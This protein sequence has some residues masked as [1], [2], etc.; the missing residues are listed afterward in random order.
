[1]VLRPALL[2]VAAALLVVTIASTWSYDTWTDQDAA[3][4][5][6]ALDS[7]FAGAA[8]GALGILAWRPRA[9][10]WALAFAGAIGVV[11]PA[12]L[13]VRSGW[14]ALTVVAVALGLVD[15]AGVMRQRA[16]ARSWSVPVVPDVD[17]ATRNAL[18]AFEWRALALAALGVAAVVFGTALWA[19]DDAAVRSFRADAVTGTALVTAVDDEDLTASATVDGRSFTLPSD[20][21]SYDVGDEVVV[22]Y[23]PTG[24]RIEDLAAVF[25]PTQ[26]LFFV[27]AGLLLALVAGGGEAG[28]RRAW[29]RLLAEGA[30]AAVVR[31][32][33]GR[34]DWV[35]LVAADATGA[36]PLARVLP[37]SLVD[38]PDGWR[39]DLG[40]DLPDDPAGHGSGG[41]S[42]RVD[43]DAPY[44][45]FP[46]SAADSPYGDSPYGGSPYGGSLDDE[47]EDEDDDLG[48]ADATDEE[49]LRAAADL[50]R[51]DEADLPVPPALPVGSEVVVVGLGATGDR[52]LLEAD[53]RWWWS[54]RPSRGHT[55]RTPARAAWTP[56]P[57]A[58]ADGSG[59]LWQ[60]LERTRDAWA[61]RT[62]RRTPLAV[63]FVLG[64]L[65]LVPLT[66]WL[67]AEL[68]ILQAAMFTLAAASV[69]F[70][71][72]HNGR[73]QLRATPD[74]VWQRGPFVDQFYRWD[75]IERF[76]TDGEAL[77]VRLG[78]DALLL[79]GGPTRPPLLSG[80]PEPEAAVRLLESARPAP[81]LRPAGNVGQRADGP[82][83]PGL[84]ALAGAVWAASVVVPAVGSLVSGG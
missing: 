51:E 24:Q 81:G 66:S 61:L 77:V 16:I 40:D 13:S 27:T 82:R 70:I 80:D 57:G 73:P 48:V 83:R 76:V 19:H 21:R 33:R 50:H 9:G 4:Y 34:G 26:S 8:I 59:N 11:D 36:A 17:R 35:E 42:G 47:D 44:G 1:M 23:D 75:R 10:V 63:P 6:G 30:P 60:R 54:E 39:R 28:R 14:A 84:A 74:G 37:T 43:G 45:H 22:R 25:D 56:S 7:L 67:A 32:G 72:V 68:N 52:I 31:V 49:L 71:W 29:R 2:V 55:L 53:G 20:V 12:N 65:V 79:A 15:R 58:V 46:A 3:G 38:D 5:A 62:A 41:W 69:G 78:D 18:L 64:P